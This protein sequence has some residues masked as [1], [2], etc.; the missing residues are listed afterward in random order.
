MTHVVFSFVVEAID[1]CSIRE[2][3]WG[4]LEQVGIIGMC[5]A[6]SDRHRMNLSTPPTPPEIDETGRCFGVFLSSR[7]QLQCHN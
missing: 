1:V 7:W 2:R 4:V 3:T 6:I 5:V